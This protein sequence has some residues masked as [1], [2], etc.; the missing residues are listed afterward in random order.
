M[1]K[2]AQL[3]GFSA[4]ADSGNGGINVES[5]GGA[6][7]LLPNVFCRFSGKI[8]F[9]LAAVDSNRSVGLLGFE[10]FNRG[11]R[12]LAAADGV[13]IFIFCQLLNC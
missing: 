10:E 12:G 8:F 1:D 9:N 13:D 5:I 3:A 2:S 11:H 6:K 4:A 7:R